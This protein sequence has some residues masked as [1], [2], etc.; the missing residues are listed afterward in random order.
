MRAITFH[1][2]FSAALFAVNPGFTPAW[3]QIAGTAN[4]GGP[5][6]M[7]GT[8]IP[9]GDFAA[10]AKRLGLVESAKPARELIKGWETPRKILVGVDNNTNR[11]A[12][13]Q[14]AAPGVKL[15][16]VR[17]PE[18]KNREIADA[19]G[20]LRMPCRREDFAVARR[21]RWIQQGSV[22]IAG[23]SEITEHTTVRQQVPRQ[24]LEGTAVITNLQGV[25]TRPLAEHAIAMM[26]ALGRGLDINVLQQAKGHFDKTAIPPGRL[27]VFE[28][29]TL[30]VVGLG[31]IGR[32]VAQLAHGLGM[33]VIATDRSD[34]PKPDTVNY[35]GRPE[36]LPELVAK[37]DA[38]VLAVPLTPQ[39]HHLFDAAMFARMKKGALLINVASGGEVVSADLVA[40]LK[41]GQL[42]GAGLDLADP[43]NPSRLE[44]NDPLFGAP[45]LIMSPETASHAIDTTAA[46]GGEDMWIIV[47]E[48]LKRYVAGDK[49]YSVVD[50]RRGW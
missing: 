8:P 39:T 27:W 36:Q 1:F 32:Q 2:A 41:S 28:G 15:V 25:L 20:L 9:D 7:V 31:G 37:A 50:P 35:V 38:V 5:Q 10:V 12:W 13:L 30:L 29:R 19:D 33:T 42:G 26:M 23:C 40:A 6:P 11:L 22:T 34:R 48:N 46:S 47:R 4:L 43:A 17:T 24:L 49:L 18:E 16:A 3:G 14:A 21:L 44:P 45:N